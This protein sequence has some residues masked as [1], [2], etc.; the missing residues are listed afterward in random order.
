MAIVPTVL[1][2]AIKLAGPSAVGPG[3][4]PSST[5]A[6]DDTRVRVLG[7]SPAALTPT[8][9]GGAGATPTPTP[10][11]S[12]PLGPATPKPPPPPDAPPLT[13]Y[14]R[15]TDAWLSGAPTGDSQHLT[16]NTS[17]TLRPS[18]SMD[19]KGTRVVTVGGTATTTTQ[20]VV[21][22]GK[23]L[24]AYEGEQ[25]TDTALSDEQLKVLSKQGD[26][27]Q[28]TFLMKLVPGSKKQTDV[29]GSSRY[30]ASVVLKDVVGLL[31]KE[32]AAEIEKVLP[33]TTTLSTNM[34]ADKYDRPSTAQLTATAPEVDLKLVM[35][36][37]SYR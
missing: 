18:F 27:R 33:L 5:A 23:T 25:S 13:S 20:R 21:V 12:T 30:E 11:G 35:T 10:T 31:P 8:P 26:P 34:W 36:F 37:G 16:E 28:L 14:L 6:A 2:V 3:D 4:V 7:Q 1:L 9:L 19:A 15:V 24:T 29:F 32:Q 22:S 17:F